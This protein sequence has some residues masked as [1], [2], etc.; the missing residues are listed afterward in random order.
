MNIL[1]VS[2]LLAILLK[3]VIASESG[4]AED[5]IKAVEEEGF[6]NIKRNWWT[7]WLNRNDLF[8]YVV[9]TKE[10]DFIAE[11]INQVEDARKST[12]AA[13]FIKSPGMVDEV[14]K[15]IEYDDDD[16]RELTDHRPELI[17]S[18]VEFF[19][20][21]DRINNPKN[22]EEAVK[23]GVLNLFNFEK[24]ASVIPLISALE[25]RP[26]NKGN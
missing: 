22:Q 18:H 17:E 13:L 8:D 11:F 2:I 26:F 12:L 3:C 4:V 15:R 24:H 25:N 14:L 23:W 10:S 16:L 5:A 19:K 7:L 1:R 21:I 20:A 9:I 6:M